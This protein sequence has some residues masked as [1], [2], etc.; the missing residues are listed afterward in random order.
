MIRLDIVV[1][2]AACGILTDDLIVCAAKASDGGIFSRN[3]VAR[4][5][6]GKLRLYLISVLHREHT[7]DEFNSQLCRAHRIGTVSP[8]ERAAH[9]LIAFTA[10]FDGQQL[11]SGVL[12]EGAGGRLKHDPSCCPEAQPQ[13]PRLPSCMS[14]TRRCRRSCS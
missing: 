1:I 7:V 11:I 4:K 5:P 2:G 8:L 10:S 14:D 9:Y 13:S 12:A 3:T 6:E